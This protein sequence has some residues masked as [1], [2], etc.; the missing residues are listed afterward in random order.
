MSE[1]FIKMARGARRADM[2]NIFAD[3]GKNSVAGRHAKCKLPPAQRFQTFRC[4]GENR[5]SQQSPRAEADE[6]AKAVV[7]P[8]EQRAQ[9]AASQ[10][11]TEG[12]EELAYNGRVHYF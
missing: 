6:G 8:R 2:K 3:E 10:G 1:R 11:D 9:R 12:D 7:R 5:H 4:D